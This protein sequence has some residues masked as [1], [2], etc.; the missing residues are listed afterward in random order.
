M[1]YKC[2]SN[3][4]Q[5]SYSAHDRG[6]WYCPY[7]GKDLT[8]AGL[9]TDVYQDRRERILQPKSKEKKFFIVK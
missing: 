9:V 6:I 7:C 4:N 8:F 3:C 1:A 2:C 5:V